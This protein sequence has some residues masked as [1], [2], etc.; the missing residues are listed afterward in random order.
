MRLGSIAPRKSHFRGELV[1]WFAIHQP[2]RSTELS[3]K[4]KDSCELDLTLAGGWNSWRTTLEETIGRS[5]KARHELEEERR[6]PKLVRITDGLSKTAMLVEQSGKPTYYNETYPQGPAKALRCW[7]GR[8][9]MLITSPSLYSNVLPDSRSTFKTSLA[10]S[11][12]IARSGGFSLVSMVPL[13]FSMSPLKTRSFFDC[14][15][16]AIPSCF[17]FI[18]FVQSKS[19]G[20][21][22]YNP[23]CR[24]AWELHAA[25]PT[26]WNGNTF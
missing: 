16:E 5:S 13:S 3:H 22:V 10:S 2:M 8:S 4:T 20:Q 21:Q 25:S 15:H 18:Q 24:R 6:S 17:R 11:A 26:T 7:R 14:L 12:F 9:R 19:G 23:R 1:K